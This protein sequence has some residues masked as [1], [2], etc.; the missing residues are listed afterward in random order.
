MPH[1]ES[2]PR[3]ALALIVGLATLIL[4]TAA[5]A[6]TPWEAAHP[7]REQVLDRA[8]N[9]QRRIVEQR[10]TGE[11]SPARA[12]ALWL[13]VQSVRQQQQAIARVNG[14]GITAEQQSALNQEE[15]LISRRIGQ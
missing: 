1:P 6:E 13:Q 11:L 7:R 12:H 9:L 15:D 8:G 2:V 4:A 10:N 5:H 14:G 3:I